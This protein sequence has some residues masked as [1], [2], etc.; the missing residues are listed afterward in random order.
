VGL[1]SGTSRAHIYKGILEGLASELSIVADAL[2]SVVGR[3]EDIYVTGGGTRSTLG[4]Q[5]RA[6]ITGCRLHLMTRQ[7]A[8]SFGTA[9]LAGVGTGEYGN[10]REAVNQ[11]VRETAVLA[12]DPRITAAYKDQDRR[13]RDLRSAFVG[14]GERGENQSFEEAERPEF[15]KEAR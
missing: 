7:E 11:L 9:I 15:C 14:R 12:P 1:T 2:S 3:F 4:L 13:Y 8:V 5:L 6:A 10:V